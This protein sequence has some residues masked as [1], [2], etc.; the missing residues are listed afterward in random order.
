MSEQEEDY[1]FEFYKA[2]T[3]EPCRFLYTPILGKHRGL[4]LFLRRLAK[5]AP[6]SDQPY[7]DGV[8]HSFI[9]ELEKAL[10]TQRGVGQLE[11]FAMKNKKRGGTLKVRHNGEV[12]LVDENGKFI[13]DISKLEASP[14]VSGEKNER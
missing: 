14:D 9:E 7:G 8:W 2:I 4:H 12:Y 10:A 5:E 3:L 11:G 1:L 6:F 13:K